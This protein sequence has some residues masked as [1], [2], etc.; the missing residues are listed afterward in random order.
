MPLF[1]SGIAALLN[2]GSGHVLAGAEGGLSGNR[3]PS[4]APYQTYRAS[5]R[6]FV[7]AVGSQPLWAR[8]CDLI[9]RPDLVGH[10]DFAT[11]DRRVANIDRLEAELE[12]ALAARTADE[13][14]GLF[15]NAG[16]PAGPVNTVAE[17]FALADELERDLVVHTPTDG[18][19]MFVST[20]SPMRL[21]NHPTRVRR[22]PPAL[23]QHDDGLRA[24]LSA[25]ET[26][27]A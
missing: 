10:P 27:Q 23:G 3:H 13:W 8:T 4:I 21:S 18:D 16:V 12:E 5:D 1:D 26:E 17:A 7:L 2:V 20:R 25:D 19:G 6:V 14:I 11:N 15:Q 24:W 9:G 22:A